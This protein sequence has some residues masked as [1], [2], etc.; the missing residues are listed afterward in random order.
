MA[1]T[2]RRRSGACLGLVGLLVLA[3][4]A[5]C[6]SDSYTLATQLP[7][8][9]GDGLFEDKIAP[10]DLINVRVY[11]KEQLSTR[12]H[13]RTDGRIAMPLL[14]EVVA[15]G[16]RPR[17]LA[18]E[19]QVSLKQGGFVVSPSVVVD[20]EEAAPIKVT[21][22]GEIRRPGTI[23]LDPPMGLVHALADGGGLTEFASQS[24]I[25]VMRSMGT[26]GLTRIRFS[27]N[28]LIRG[29]PHAVGF[30]L[31]SGDVVIVE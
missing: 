2:N 24:R 13:V 1:P 19:I 16:K 14:G 17:D 3:P 11:D 26:P 25:F 20:I 9:R 10:G 7:L 5:G 4:A 30:R 18:T 22:I 6:A 12:G 8:E 28:D 15:A 23:K 27:Y 29:E 21:L 31:R